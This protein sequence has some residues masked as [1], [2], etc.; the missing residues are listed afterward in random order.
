MA[1]RIRFSHALRSFRAS[2]DLTVGPGET[3]ALVG[4]SGAGKTTVLQVV[5]GLLRPDDG[6]VA[7]GDTVLL[8]TARRVDVPPER[9]RV[10]YL[11]QEYA[12]FPHLDVWHNVRF[13]A[14]S[15]VDVEPLLERFRI[16]DLAHARV[17]QLSGGERQRVA[18]ARALAREPALL[19]LDEPLSAL[20]AHTRAG[21][22]AELRELLDELGLPVVLVTHDFE[23]AA[24]L[25]HR[26]G[27]ISDGE[28][29]QLASPTDLV[30]LPRD[31][32]VASF[33]G[34][35]VLPGRVVEVRDGLRQVAL[36]GGLTLWSADDGAGEVNVAVY[37]WDVS[38]GSVAPDDSRMNHLSAAVVSV[39]PMGNR[40][41]VRVG[42]IVAEITAASAERLDL[43]PGVLATASFKATAARLYPR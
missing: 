14:R 29:L 39:A 11:F 6:F 38:L 40:T 26:V 42:P 10:G 43:R 19:L 34:A 30:A 41:R 37:P 32:V 21:V 27:V 20:D 24:T 4:P 15:N 33:T 35:T 17:T 1:L 3:V 22:R 7:L 9:R 31:A 8:D 13:G 18:L 28:V 23:D 16:S 25:A 36:D 5:A 2:A 12:L